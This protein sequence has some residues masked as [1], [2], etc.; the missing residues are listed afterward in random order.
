MSEITLITLLWHDY[1]TWG[2]DPRRDR[3]AQ[4]AALQT[5][6]ELEEIGEPIMLYCRPTDDFLPHPEAAMLTGISPQEAATKGMNEADFFQ[7][8]NALFSQPRTCGLGYNSLR[9]DDEVT[10]FGLYRNFIDPY[11]R[12]WQN[13]NSRWDIID[14]MRMAYALR[15]EHIHWPEKEDGCVSF[16][17]ED[18]TAANGIEHSNAHDALS[19]VRATI[20]LARLIKRLQPRLYTY[21]F[22]LRRKHEAAQML[23]LREPGIVLHVS[24]MYPTALGCMA[25]VVPLLQHPRNTNEIIVYDLRQ[26]PQEFLDMTVDEIEDNLYTRTEEL[27]E[28]VER[29]GLKGVHLNKSPALAPVNTLTP[30]LAD[31]W[32]IHWQQIKDHYQVLLAENTLENLKNRLQELYLRVSDIEP[33]DVDVALYGTF[34]SNSD[35]RI[36]DTL[37]QKS[38][39]Q[40]AEWKPDFQDKRLQ[41]LY[42]R[43]RARN[44]PETLNAKERDQWR[45]FCEDR[46]LAGKFGHPLTLDKYQDILEEMLE[47]GI[48]E[49]RQDLFKKLVEWVQ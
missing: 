41:R 10:R 46:L 7:K 18:L 44:W 48:P 45:Q 16:N 43:Y 47:Q 14:L 32:Q 42:F 39:E 30:E 22:N 15:P 5:N 36:C 11:A 17:L 8:I 13:E 12:E 21:F 33:V 3:P 19:D 26:N 29:I 6:S 24:G 2:I 34:I 9:F 49:N 23:N 40:L 35:R 31:K 28:G 27:P 25:P 38:P 1:E 20:A 37:L 4:F